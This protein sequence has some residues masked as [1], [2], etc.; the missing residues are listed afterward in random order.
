MLFSQECKPDHSAGL[1][2]YAIPMLSAWAMLFMLSV[3][4][5]FTLL[6]HKRNY[7]CEISL[8]YRK[9]AL[10]K[11]IVRPFDT[12]MVL[13]SVFTIRCVLA[14]TEFS[15]LLLTLCLHARTEYLLIW[16]GVALQFAN[17]SLLLYFWISACEDSTR[18]RLV[19]NKPRLRVSLVSLVVGF[20]FLTMMGEIFPTDAEN[21]H[22]LVTGFL[23]LAIGMLFIGNVGFWIFYGLQCMR[24]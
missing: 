14:I 13:F 21:T 23:N 5:L 22:Q 15:V 16:G 7:R 18:I 2:W 12:L 6:L 19:E 9:T 10:V 17:F 3:Y 1:Q 11:S 8:T 4:R 24:M 20:I